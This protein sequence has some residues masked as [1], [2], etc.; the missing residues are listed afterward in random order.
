MIALPRPPLDPERLSRLRCKLHA[1]LLH[2]HMPRVVCAS[3]LHLFKW[4]V[5]GAPVEGYR[6]GIRLV[7]GGKYIEMDEDG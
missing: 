6:I 4:H 5:C 2:V 3:P 7:G 1:V